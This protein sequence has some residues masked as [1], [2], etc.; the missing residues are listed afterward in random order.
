MALK[1]IRAATMTLLVVLTFVSSMNG[2]TSPYDQSI[3]EWRQTYESLLKRSWLLVSGLFWLHEGENRFGSDPLNDI[4]LP[5]AAGPAVAGSFDFHAGK[6]V[7]HVNRGAPVAVNGK[8]VDSAEVPFGES[9]RLSLG[10]LTLVIHTSGERYAL[11]LWDKNSRLLKNFSGLQW[12]PVNESYRVTAHYSAYNS[13]K[14]VELPNIIGDSAKVSI[15][16]YVTFSL[17]GQ[18]YRLEAETYR[19]GKLFIIF[20]DLTSGKETYP[21]ARFLETDVPKDG[22][23][24]LDFNKAH[25]PPCA[26]N[27]YTTCPLPSPGNRL[28]VEIPAGEKDYKHKAEVGSAP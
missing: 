8:A 6:I 11:R 15:A 19:E 10:D 1:R 21:A 27:P 24:E 3:A 13:P 18:E 20:R 12:Y 22:A 5:G 17:H 14:D 28:R 2:Y 7:V 26:Y 16:G 9:D 23:V 25:N 4:V